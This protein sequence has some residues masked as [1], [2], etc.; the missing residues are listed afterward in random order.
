MFRPYWIPSQ[1]CAFVAAIFIILPLRIEIETTDAVDD[2]KN[3]I[4][5]NALDMF[6]F[7]SALDMP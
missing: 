3:N 1:L 7:W 5:H 4:A 6:R 2:E